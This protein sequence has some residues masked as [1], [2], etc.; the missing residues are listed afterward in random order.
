MSVDQQQASITSPPR[1]DPPELAEEKMAPKRVT[2]GLIQRVRAELWELME[3]T[4]LGATDVINRAISLYRL[5]TMHQK[6][7]YDMVLRHRD[8]GH[9]RVVEIL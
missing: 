6:A 1:I 9:E 3:I 5:V 7:G 4:T 8:S 2:V